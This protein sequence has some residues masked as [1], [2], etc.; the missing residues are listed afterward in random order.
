MAYRAHI[1]E[2]A[3][4][5]RLN[6]VRLLIVEEGPRGGRAV[7]EDGQWVEV[8]EAELLPSNAG[9]LLPKASIAAILE[10]FRE[11]QG[12]PK[13]DSTTEAAVLREWLKVE[14]DRVDHLVDSVLARVER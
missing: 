8:H 4:D 12:R 5:W 13:V 6:T 10:A 11:W 14:K 9:I 7:N 1:G 3:E 2:S